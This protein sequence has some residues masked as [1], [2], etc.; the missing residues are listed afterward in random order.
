[1]HRA[2]TLAGYFSPAPSPFGYTL[3]GR[4]R[5]ASRSLRERG[6]MRNWDCEREALAIPIS[7]FLSLALGELPNTF[8]II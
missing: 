6:K 3:P 7:L 8:K 1:M 2:H 4:L 5:A